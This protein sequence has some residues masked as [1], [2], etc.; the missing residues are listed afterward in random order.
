VVPG[1]LSTVA[2]SH[3]DCLAD[4][5]DPPDL[6]R[7]ATDGVGVRAVVELSD[8]FDAPLFSSVLKGASPCF[9]DDVPQGVGAFEDGIA[10]GEPFEIDAVA[11]RGRW[12]HGCHDAR[13]VLT[14]CCAELFSRRREF[15]PVAGALAV[16]DGGRLERLDGCVDDEPENSQVQFRGELM[17]DVHVYLNADFGSCQ[18]P[19]VVFGDSRSITRNV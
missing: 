8:G 7:L 12:R 10:P 14:P 18:W 1:L 19:A 13:N 3:E 16:W 9:A 17:T 15:P 2:A 5:R 6:S 4:P 11:H